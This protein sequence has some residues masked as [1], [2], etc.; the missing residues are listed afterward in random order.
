M[1]LYLPIAGYQN[2][3]G[4]SDGVAWSPHSESNKTTSTIV[5]NLRSIDRRPWSK[6]REGF[7]LFY[8]IINVGTSGRTKGGIID[9]VGRLGGFREISGRRGSGWCGAREGGSPGGGRRGKGGGKRRA[10]WWCSRGSRAW[11]P[12]WS[13]T[14]IFTGL[15]GGDPSFAMS[16][17]SRCKALI[18]LVLTFWRRFCATSTYVIRLYVLVV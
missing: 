6:G 18:A 13:L 15:S 12:I 5:G 9:E 10:S 7:I 11:R 4:E 2:L 8:C 14:S 1:T 16:I 3:I 17:S